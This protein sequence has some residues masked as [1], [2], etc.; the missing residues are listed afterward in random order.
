MST[1]ASTV[2][3]RPSRPPGFD[4]TYQP[5]EQTFGPPWLSRLPSLVY[6]GAALC[7][8]G[9]LVVGES[10]GSNSSLFD[11]VV[12]QDRNRTMGMRTFA[13]VL[14]VGSVASVLRSGMRGV[15]V[16]PGG[17]EARDIRNWFIPYVRRY[18]WPQL[19]KIILD[20]ET[21][22]AVDLWDGRRECLPE[23]NDRPGLEATL[24]RVALARAIPIS[25]GS[26]FET[27]EDTQGAK[28]LDASERSAA[29]VEHAPSSA[30]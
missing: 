7:V 12:A 2:A 10:S 24:E 28:M 11:F 1:P 17:V 5:E 6:L 4:M 8:A 21:S 26:G 25:G 9:I 20:H 30:G 22:V 14:M 29:E 15:R 18:T 13:I 27:W 19:E 23:V 16:F 3:E